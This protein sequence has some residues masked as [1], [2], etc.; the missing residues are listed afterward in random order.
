MT[1]VCTD[2]MAGQLCRYVCTTDACSGDVEL[3][4]TE[5]GTW[6]G[7]NLP[8]CESNGSH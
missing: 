1:G 3:R 8:S 4:C 2:A 6:V 5:D 7:G